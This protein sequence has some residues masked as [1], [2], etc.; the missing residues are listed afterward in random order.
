MIQVIDFFSGCGGTSCGFQAAGLEILAGIDI[1]TD[2]T[3]TYKQNFPAATVIEGD[4]KTMNPSALSAIIGKRKKPLLFA[5]CAPCQPFSRQNRST[6]GADPR[7]TLLAEFGR[8]VKEWLPE[9]I[10]VENV[11]GMQKIQSSGPLHTFQT[12]LKKLGYQ[13]ECAVVPA[14]WYGVP[15][16][17]ERLI[18]I[19][20]LKTS[21][22]IP[23]PT[24][25]PDAPE[26]GY[27][28][29]ANWIK[30]L[31]E[32]SAGQTHPS[33]PDHSAAKLADINLQRI[34]ATPEGGSR[35]SW[36][37]SLWLECHKNYSG[38]SDVYG[39]LAWNKQASGLTTR[40]TSYSNGRF[41]H[42]TQ[43]RAISVREAACL[44]TFPR[45]Y[46]FTGTL[47]SK[48]RQ[49]G[50]A[51]PPRMAEAFGKAFLDSLALSKKS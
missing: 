21:V 12:L 15:Q 14:L 36:P 33:D 28:T 23:A 5:G 26:G 44:Q 2:A 19:A 42:P 1:D 11:P 22:H 6:N 30:D 48:A 41:G 20:S 9:Y 51:V 34:R 17:R 38:H 29:V 3:T 43:D 18:L 8:F 45:S 31:P 35:D 47:T 4:L 39:R 37:R 25:G 46:E 40:C 24:H 32:I 50:N 49:I 27:T 13:F 7:R 10:F 16:K